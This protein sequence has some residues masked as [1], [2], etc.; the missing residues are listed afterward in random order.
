[1][2]VPTR[3]PLSPLPA[4]GERSD[5]AAIRVR[6]PT[7]ESER[8]EGLWQPLRAHELR[9]LRRVEAPPHPDP[10]PARGGREHG[11]AS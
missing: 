4:C 2:I 10:L 8:L 6:G 5:R 7:Q 9:R 1:M 11:A 3:P